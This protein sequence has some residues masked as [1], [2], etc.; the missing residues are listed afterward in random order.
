MADIFISHKTAL[1]LF[2]L[3]QDRGEMKVLHRMRR[4]E[5]DP[6]RKGNLAGDMIGNAEGADSA[7]DD[8]VMTEVTLEGFATGLRRE[9]DIDLGFLGPVHTGP[10]DI[11]V[12]SQKNSHVNKDV[13]HHIWAGP[14]PAG[15]YLR[16]GEHVYVSSPEFVLLQMAAKLDKYQTLQLAMQLCGT[17]AL[18]RTAKH[19]MIKHPQLTSKKKLEQ[20]ARM[21][22]GRRAGIGNF[23]WAIRYVIDGAASPTE[24]GTALMLSMPAL[25]GG[26]GLRAFKLNVEKKYDE[27]EREITRGKRKC[28]VD[29]LDEESRFGWEYQGKE[30]HSDAENGEQYERDDGRAVGGG[31]GDSGITLSYGAESLESD[32]LK[33]AALKHMEY[34]VRQLVWGQIK[35]V[36]AFDQVALTTAEKFEAEVEGAYAFSKN[37]KLH[38][39]RL[40]LHQGVIVQRY[41]WQDV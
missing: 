24:A 9:R 31:D 30:G 27:V 13:R 23:R 16:L 34:D 2:F 17:Y 32:T 10:I 22:E 12:A 35:T 19:G 3:A 33:L 11:L 40:A 8:G 4:P 26:Y 1:D 14:I 25:S 36:A 39:R 6:L 41:Y 38:V 21:I 5:G 20:F 29:L 15:G 28:F 37:E 18:L 7:K